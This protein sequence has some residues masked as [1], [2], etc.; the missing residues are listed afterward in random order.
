[1]LFVHV[2][3][4]IAMS[5]RWSTGDC[6]E[7]FASAAH[8]VEA[9]VVHPRLA[10]CPLEP[11][12]IAAAFDAATGILTVWLSTQTPHRSR[13]ELARIIGVDDAAL[14]IVAPDVGGAFGMKA[15]LY[16]EEVFVAWAALK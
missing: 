6:D 3:D 10:P 16:P 9:D 7:A 14:R 13:K 8:V 2:P 5:Q 4:N 15:S 12:G 11:R 1:R